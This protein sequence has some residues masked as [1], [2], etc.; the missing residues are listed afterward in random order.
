MECLIDDRMIYI[1]ETVALDLVYM[2]VKITD[3]ITVYFSIARIMLEA[4]DALL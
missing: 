3:C 2:V 4:V 1:R